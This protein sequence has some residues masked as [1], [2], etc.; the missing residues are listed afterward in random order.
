MKSQINI[1]KLTLVFLILL[2][3]PL[4]SSE[5]VVT[6][7]PVN[8]IE[9]AGKPAVLFINASSKSDSLLKYRWYLDNKKINGADFPVLNFDSL[10]YKNSG[11]YFCRVSI[12]DFVTYTDSDKSAVYI[13]TGTSITLEPNDIITGNNKGTVILNFKAQLNSLFNNDNKLIENV[14]KS[15][16][17]RSFENIAVQLEDNEI[18]AGT[19]TDELRINIEKLPD[20]SYFFA[21][22]EGKCGTAKTRT[23]RIIKNFR[24]ISLKL[25][26]YEFC[27]GKENFISAEIFN[28]DSLKIKFQWY[29]DGKPLSPKH[30][31]SGIYSS[32]LNFA[33]SLVTDSG[34]YRLKATAENYGITFFSNENT[35]SVNKSPRIICLRADTLKFDISSNH[36]SAKTT[37]WENETRLGIYFEKNNLPC[38]FDIFRNN[39][40]IATLKS[41]NSKWYLND[42]YF[43]NYDV[44]RNYTDKYYILARNTCGTD[45][46]DT[47]GILQNGDCDPFNQ[48]QHICELE[49]YFLSVNYEKKNKQSDYDF[50]WSDIYQAAKFDRKA[51]FKNFN[52]NII[53][54]TNSYILTS[55]EDR[56]Q[57]YHY[58]HHNITLKALKVR[59]RDS[60]ENDESIFCCF[61]VKLDFVPIINEQP[62]NT[63]S[64]EFT[65]DTLFR[66]TFNNKP[67]LLNDIFVA[68]YY[69]ESLNSEPK[70][71]L[72][73]LADEG[74]KFTYIKVIE[75]NDEGYYFALCRINNDCNPVSSDTVKVSVTEKSIISDISNSKNYIELLIYPNPASNF[76][77][78]SYNHALNNT[79]LKE[80]NKY[81]KIINQFGEEIFTL[82]V[83]LSSIH[84]GTV[85]KRI[86]ISSFITGIYFV[87]YNNSFQKFIKY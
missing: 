39:E 10:E 15:Q 29:K 71:I 22:T 58:N 78:I 73:A 75:K 38:E 63:E 83:D 28:P 33:P 42:V 3:T 35:V 77:D 26:N 74:T 24:G 55:A 19:Q 43:L 17:Y 41:E 23:A 52:S 37:G 48:Y 69:L 84:N 86:N 68:L 2:N 31:L 9:C 56:F 46:S 21:K 36:F 6:Q 65:M 82:P 13:L 50:Y 34:S 64:E 79:V 45:W 60:S 40:I 8:I 54:D 30:N 76:I 14:F 57:G 80:N 70:E 4:F 85:S 32:I 81:L 49:D 5:I 11:T 18:F 12:N 27:D 47:V 72:T 1:I 59:N 61:D 25:E 16:W 66:I 62:E 7:H 51:P 53:I 44:E 20:T 87:I 67:P